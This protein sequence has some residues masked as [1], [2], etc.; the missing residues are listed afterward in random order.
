M[1]FLYKE[2]II[3]FGLALAT[4]SP[5]PLCPAATKN[6]MQQAEKALTDFAVNLF[7]N[8]SAPNENKNQVMSPVSIAL[9]LAMLE[10]GADGKT[11]EELRNALVGIGASADVLAT[12][13]SIQKQLEIDD[14]KTKLSIAN[15]LFVEK[16]LTLKADYVSRSQN[17]LEAEVDNDNDFEHQ[18]EQTRQKIN[19]WVSD[20]TA[21]KIYELF[22]KGSLTEANRMVM[23]NAI[24]Y[25]APWKNTFDKS[26]TQHQAFYKDGQETKQ[27]VPFMHDQ[28]G[29]HYATTQ[30]LDALELPYDNQDLSMYILL[31]KTRDGLNDLEK[32]L[33]GDQLRSIIAS[34]M[35]QFID[36]QLPRF[37]IR[38]N[39]ELPTVLTK[40]GLD[41]VFGNSA[42]FSRM[43]EVQLT[44]DSAVHEAYINVHENGTEAAAATGIAITPWVVLPV[45]PIPFVADHPFLY[46]IVHRPTGA[47][48]F[49]G[50]VTSVQAH[51]DN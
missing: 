41:A 22:K 26:K 11:R 34:M 8:V 12:Y 47:P 18:L 14:G 37:E 49:F 39:I 4:C 30:D 28:Y 36:V 42:D 44:V 32:K 35:Q 45:K 17:C 6:D 1:H 31:P 25:K 10:N 33:T 7:K 24:Y 21:G 40:L 48:V 19:K 2:L 51:N 20:K 38:S 50:K 23:A 5:V 3:V 27:M 9:T 46:A 29:Y 15:G 13:M 43:S 16:D